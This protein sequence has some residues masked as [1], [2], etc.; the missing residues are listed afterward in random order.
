MATNSLIPTGNTVSGLGPSRHATQG[1]AGT[2]KWS[3]FN[4]VVH[5]SV[6]PTAKKKDTYTLKVVVASLRRTD[7]DKPH[8]DVVDTIYVAITEATANQPF[9]L[10][11]VKDNVGD[12]QVIVAADGYEIKESSGTEGTSQT[13]YSIHVLTA[14]FSYLCIQVLGSG[15][16]LHERVTVET[17]TLAPIIFLYCYFV[18][19]NIFQ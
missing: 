17:I 13:L 9:I 5:T 10:A 8:F 15:S 6:R 7:G 18:H 19:L 12:E 1:S 4:S 11:A 14:D 3:G 2:A 16:Q